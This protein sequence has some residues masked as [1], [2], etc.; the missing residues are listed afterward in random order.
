MVGRRR[1]DPYT[2]PNAT[3]GPVEDVRRVESLLADWDDVVIAIS[4]VMHE[5]KA[6]D[7]SALLAAAVISGQERVNFTYS[8]LVPLV[9]K[10]SVTSTVKWK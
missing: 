2:L 1:L 3:A 8:S 6:G 4:W 9:D 5:D 10:W 7:L